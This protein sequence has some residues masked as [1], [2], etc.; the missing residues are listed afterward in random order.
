MQIALSLGR[1]LALTVSDALP[2]SLVDIDDRTRFILAVDELGPLLINFDGKL[3]WAEWG[4]RL[5][6]VAAAS[7]VSMRD[8]AH[9]LDQ[10]SLALRLWAGCLDAAKA[11]A[12]ETRSGPNTPQQRAAIFSGVDT[13]AQADAAYRAGVEAAPAFKRARD[14]G[15]DLDGVPD[16]SAVRRFA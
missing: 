9:P 13:I 3:Q 7:A 12:F 4:K 6:K 16:D 14:Q 1:G 2:Q 15:Y 5:E 11:I 8:V 10:V